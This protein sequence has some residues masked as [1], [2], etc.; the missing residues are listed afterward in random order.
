V[1]NELMPL[2]EAM[3]KGRRYEG[4]G[5]ARRIIRTLVAK[6]DRLQS[7]NPAAQPLEPGGSRDGVHR[8]QHRCEHCHAITEHDCVSAFELLRFQCSQCGQESRGN[9]VQAKSGGGQ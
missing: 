6:I 1:T 9:R 7:E 3:A 2:I 5:E 4:D 8:Q